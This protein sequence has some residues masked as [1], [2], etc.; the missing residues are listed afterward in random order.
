MGR[1]TR[2]RRPIGGGRASRRTDESG[3]GL[4]EV[5]IALIILSVG[6]LSVAGISLSVGAQTRWST[7]QTD[8]SLAA[9]E[10]L[11]RVQREGFDAAA[12]GTETVGIDNRE[13]VVTRTVTLVEPRVKEVEVS[14]ESEHVSA[15]TFTTRLYKERPLPPPPSP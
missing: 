5:L 10:V 14:V 7:W 1:S 9:Q 11:E 15:R 8:Q 13:Y 6:M 12:S 2:P 3:I 4:V